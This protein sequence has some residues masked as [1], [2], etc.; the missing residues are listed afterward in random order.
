M[1]NKPIQ[2]LGKKYRYFL[3]VDNGKF[4]LLQVNRLGKGNDSG[5]KSLKNIIDFTHL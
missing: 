4:I 1:R 5:F 2:I 3:K